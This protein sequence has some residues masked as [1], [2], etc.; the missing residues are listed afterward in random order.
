MRSFEASLHRLGLARI[1]ILYLHDLGSDTHGANHRYMFEKAVGGGF[2]ALTALR[3]Q[4]AVTAIG[5]G[6]NEIE[7]CAE[8]MV[9]A[10][11]DLFLIAGRFT[12]LDQDAD[13]F[14]ETCRER[15][16]GVVA[17]GVFNSGILATG[18]TDPNAHYDYAPASRA[19]RMRVAAIERICDDF[20]VPLPAAALQFAA[21]H[22]AV[23]LPVLGLRTSAE[24][25][26][27]VN[28][29]AHSIPSEFWTALENEGLILA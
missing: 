25:A 7:I 18:S 3:E 15:G 26:A 16:I 8:S 12:L 22:P 9:H 11:F 4:G 13:T 28:H 24:V 23:T 19:L 21:R 29:A 2:Q 20:G 5:L 17:G 27:A 10:D 14:F 6:V 1:D